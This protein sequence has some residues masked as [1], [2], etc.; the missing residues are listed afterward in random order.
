MSDD[1]TN[2]NEGGSAYSGRLG[3]VAPTPGWATDVAVLERLMG[4]RWIDYPWYDDST[5]RLFWHDN[6]G[7]P[8]GTDFGRLEDDNDRLIPWQMPQPTRSILSAWEVVERLRELGCTV[9]IWAGP[10]VYAVTV[11]RGAEKFS[12]EAG[13]APLAI[14][15]VALSVAA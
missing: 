9:T 6:W 13:T 3:G 8:E 15:R 1:Q 12:A 11:W 10:G 4:W 5:K 2:S 14:S 7:I